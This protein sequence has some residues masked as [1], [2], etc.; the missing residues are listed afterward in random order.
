MRAMRLVWEVVLGVWMFAGLAA[1]DAQSPQPQS[2]W[3][4]PAAELAGQ[5][6]DILGPGQ[7]QL[8]LRN[9]SSIQTSEIPAIRKLMEQDLKAHGVLASGAES[10]NAVRV[11]LS[12]DARERLWVA[13]VV[14][15][16]ETHVAMVHVDASPAPAG[17][18]AELARTKLRS[19]GRLGSRLGWRFRLWMMCST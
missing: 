3:A 19:C 18:M 7:V 15:G 5:I 1:G 2:R 9:L 4:Q 6:A 12:E 10:A 14:E 8:S 16:S 11:T 13:E 17:F